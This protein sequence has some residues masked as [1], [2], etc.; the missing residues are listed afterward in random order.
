MMVVFKSNFSNDYL[1][2]QRGF[3]AIVK[4]GMSANTWALSQFGF[5]RN[6]EKNKQRERLGFNQVIVMAV[7]VIV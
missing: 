7:G 4:A 3:Q 5:K 2:T 6:R 1:V